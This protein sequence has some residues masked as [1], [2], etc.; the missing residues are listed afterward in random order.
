MLEKYKSKNKKVLVWTYT[1]KNAQIFINNLSPSTNLLTNKQQAALI[2]YS[3]YE[4]IKF[5]NISITMLMGLLY[6]CDQWK[7]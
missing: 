4:V 1:Y 3:S 6:N 5:R 2:G 7:W